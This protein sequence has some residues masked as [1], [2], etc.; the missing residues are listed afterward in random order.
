MERHQDAAAVNEEIRYV[1]FI[2]KEPAMKNNRKAGNTYKTLLLAL[3]SL[4]VSLFTG[5]QALAAAITQCDGCHGM[6][7]I[8]TPS[9]S[10]A[11]YRNV[12]TGAVK[13]N[14]M[15]HAPTALQKNNCVPCHGGKVLNYTNSHRSG[16]INVTGNINTSPHPSKATYQ[17]GT[18]F[19][20]SNNPSLG[21]CSNVNCHFERVTPVWGTAAFASPTDCNKC[22]GTPPSGTAPLY[23]GGRD[24]SHSKHET[25]Y[26]WAANGCAKCH[27]DHLAE[28]NKFAH[29]TSVGQRA[30]S[31]QLHDPDGTNS[32]GTYSISSMNYL[33]SQVSSHLFGTCSSIY[34]HSAGTA[35]YT[36]P[37]T[38]P[39]WGATLGCGDCHNK[40]GDASWSGTTAHL[41]HVTAYI[42]NSSINCNSCHN[43]TASNSSTISDKTKH[44]NKTTEVSFNTFASGSYN[45]TTC[46]NTY[47]HSNGQNPGAPTHAA[48]SWKTPPTVTCTSCHGD[49]ASGTLSGRHDRHVNN[50]TTA[51]SGM[52]FGC[53]DCHSKTVSNDSTIAAGGYANHVNKMVD[54]S[55]VR[56][57]NNK[58][59]STFYCHSNGKV[60][61]S[62]VA[63]GTVP[64]WT[65]AAA[66]NGL[67]CNAC[68]G[69]GS[70]YGEPLYASG[71][72]GSA[73][74]NSHSKH[75]GAATDCYR[76][77]A[78]TATSAGGAVNIAAGLHINGDA[79]DVRFSKVHPTFVSV[80]GSYTKASKTC[81]ATYCHG[82]GNP[83]WGANGTLNCESCHKASNTLKGKHSQ[84][85]ESATAATSYT[86]APGN[87]GT[88]Q[89]Q[90]QCSA[91]HGNNISNHAG[92]PAVS[93]DRVATMSF[94]FYTTAGLTPSY[95]AG[96]AQTD[97]AF[98]YTAG[99][100]SNIYCHSN[101]NG[102]APINT[103]FTWAAASPALDC[104]GCH[105]KAGDASW[106]GTA[107]HTKHII[108]Y[109]KNTNIGCA[110]CHTLTAASNTTLA[111]DKS[112]HVNK[113]KNVDFNT[114]AG[115][116]WDGT[117]CSTTYCHSNG[118]NLT[119]PTANSV[120]WSATITCN[121]CHGGDAANPP[122][123]SAHAK[124]VSAA[125]G[126]K[127]NCATCHN[128]TV[129]SPG[130]AS[131]F[132]TISSY[133]LHVN[134][135][136]EV[137]GTRISTYAYAAANASS[138]TTECH[139]KTTPKWNET[140]TGC[141]FCHPYDVG[142]WNTTAQRWTAQMSAS[143]QGFGAHEKHITNIKNRLGIATLAANPGYG[144]GDAAIVCGTCHSNTLADHIDV[145]GTRN[146]SFSAGSV[147]AT[148][149]QFGASAPLYNGASG[150]SSATQAKTCSNLSCHYFITP[151]WSTY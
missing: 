90:F 85:W 98:R 123:S 93:L 138:C 133:G 33:P 100:C 1:V 107:A 129:K 65:T 67:A 113:V 7:P 14:H 61:T 19:A 58:S 50:T 110:T 79:G 34:C 71:A 36:A 109:A 92:G 52:S 15:T 136:Y 62:A 125:N 80:S 57:G 108:T 45:G 75:V 118:S 122:A 55:G 139:G 20:Q 121:S 95:T 97:D 10:L 18:I 38:T 106:S 17:R 59:C 124:H 31:M 44:V 104:G 151:I 131:V 51:Y 87:G 126:Y 8:D 127:Y 89:Y 114:W 21:T 25:Y 101:G 60:G 27:S 24:G 63:Y 9:T 135:S 99:S 96:A 112:K 35:S 6:P 39:Q 115:G 78:K 84:H 12:T 49:K 128:R 22:H 143:S 72:A 132:S 140:S 56:A 141:N 88:T 76:C 66:V 32:V 105:N 68:H 137:A 148:G 47:C 64:A 91:C 37:I 86:A 77:H 149:L 26:S 82:A 53:V 70:T 120:T 16:F 81:S 142:T 4:F 134:K 116:S 111:S 5:G 146:I 29:A 103:S 48:I 94:M 144:A 147:G 41:K 83:V 54:Y 102:G 117:T 30:L 23:D 40:A 46:S 119:T 145:S 150:T 73:T 42:T 43:L 13:G 3:F 2:D 28:T 130:D 74:A 69:A 11:T